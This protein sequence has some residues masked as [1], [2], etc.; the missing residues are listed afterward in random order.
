MTKMILSPIMRGISRS[1]TNTFFCH[2]SYDDLS[3]VIDFM[4][5]IFRHS[6]IK[7]T[8]QTVEVITT[9]QPRGK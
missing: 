2:K 1:M 9:V 6:S 5:L 7:K 4:T 8:S 3:F